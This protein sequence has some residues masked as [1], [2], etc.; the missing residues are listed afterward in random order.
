MPSRNRPRIRVSILSTL[1]T[2]IPC[3]H[4][5]RRQGRPGAMRATG[6]GRALNWIRE[7]WLNISQA[8]LRQ[9]RDG[10]LRRRQ[11]DY[12]DRYRLHWPAR[13]V[14][15]LA[16]AISI[17]I[18]LFALAGAQPVVEINQF[19]GME[20]AASRMSTILELHHDDGQQY[21]LARWAQRYRRI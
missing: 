5:R 20:I 16:T 14:P 7:G 11:T 13:N 3:R 12:V 21:T 10:S 4:G 6:A 9:A 8:N 2:C 18:A 17:Q 19:A 1:P 15:C